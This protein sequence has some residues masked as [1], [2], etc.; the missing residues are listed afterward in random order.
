MKPLSDLVDLTDA[1]GRHVHSKVLAFGVTAAVAVI[2]G[3]NLLVGDRPLTWPE[4]AILAAL[5]VAP[6]GLDGFKTLVK[7]RFGAGPDAGN[8][9]RAIGTR[10]SLG[11]MD[12]V[13][14]A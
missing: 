1:Q 11:A 13:E 9:G 12:G 7:L 14:P 10:R 6:Y 2:V 8:G 3:L 5:L 4:A